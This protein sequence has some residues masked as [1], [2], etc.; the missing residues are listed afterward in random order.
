MSY[1]LPYLIAAFHKRY[2]EVAVTTIDGNTADI[3]AAPASVDVALVE[4]PTGHDLS[5]GITVTA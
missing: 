3:V 5:L 4:G 1:V 2:P